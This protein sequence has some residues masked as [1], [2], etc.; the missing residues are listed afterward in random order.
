MYIEL[1]RSVSWSFALSHAVLIILIGQ[2]HSRF[3]AASFRTSPTLKVSCHSTLRIKLAPIFHSDAYCLDPLSKPSGAD[4]SRA[5][6]RTKFYYLYT[7][8]L[9]L[10]LLMPA[11]RP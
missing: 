10:V 5:I 3:L 6:S 9:S 1:G 11:G 2:L 4:T 8:M 7:C